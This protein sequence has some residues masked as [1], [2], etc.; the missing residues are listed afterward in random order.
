[1]KKE[2]VPTSDEIWKIL[3]RVSLAQEKDKE[4]T[5]RLRKENDR[6]IRENKAE[7]ERQIKENRQL[8]RESKAE[9]DRQ[10]KETERQKKENRQLI[11]ESKAETERQIK[12]NRLFIKQIDSRWGNE[13]GKLVE[14]LIEGN[15]LQLLNERGIKVTK[16][17]PNYKGVR[18]NQ[19]KEFDLIATNGQEI[20][21]IET[22]SSLTKIKVDQFLQVM[23]HFKEYCSEF[24]TLTVY[25][26][27]ACLKST[28]ETLDYA[29][30]KGLLV[31]RVS[32][33]NA[34][35]EN[36][37]NFKPKVFGHQPTGK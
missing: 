15:F 32:G 12:E 21:V 20:V 23:R 11:W 28:Q 16:A 19:V 4:A 5:E 33:Q 9:T 14:A 25:G 30:S 34:V 8:I 3:K 31:L 13:W 17:N 27:M 36:K 26:G 1:M 2:P 35:L 22:K 24:S 6:L 29:E 10:R 18:Q 7:T 37:E